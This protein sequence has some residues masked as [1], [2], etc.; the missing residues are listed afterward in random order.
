MFWSTLSCTTTLIIIRTLD[1]LCQTGYRLASTFKAAPN[2]PSV[3]RHALMQMGNPFD[4]DTHLA[5]GQT[6]YRILTDAGYP[7]E[8]FW[9]FCFVFGCFESRSGYKDRPIG[10]FSPNP[11]VVWRSLLWLGDRRILLL[12]IYIPAP[13]TESF[14]RLGRRMIFKVAG[15]GIELELHSSSW[16]FSEYLIH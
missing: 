7:K 13:F 14:D 11:S 6:I 9:C 12:C 5:I 8:N 2:S 1:I 4:Q 3:D 10:R 16:P 15:A